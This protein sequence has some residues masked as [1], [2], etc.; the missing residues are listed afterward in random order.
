MKTN[1]YK[2]KRVFLLDGYGRQIPS[3]LH[4]LH[5]LGCITTV[6]CTSRLNAG[7]TSRYPKKK[8]LVP[9]LRDDMVAYRAAIMKELDSFPYDVIFP[10]LERTT[11]FCTSSEFHS[12]Y[13]DLKVISANR[14]AF[15]KAYDKQETLRTCQENGVPCPI[16]K[17]D[18]ETLDE[19]LAKVQFPLAAKPRKGSGGVGF[20]RIADRAMLDAYLADGTIKLEEYVLQEL[21]PKGGFQYAAFSMFG[22][23][24][25]PIFTLIAEVPRWFPIDGGPSCYIRTVDR[26]DIAQYATTLLEKLNW[27]GFSHIDFI[28]D[29]RDGV[30]KVMEINGR[31]PANVKICEWMGL[32][33]VKTMLDLVYGKNIAPNTKPIPA[34]RAMRYFHTDLLWFLKNPERFRAKPSWFYCLHQKDYIFSWKDPIPFFSYAIEHA[35]NYKKDMKKRQH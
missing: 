5:T 1:E 14:E 27:I 10:V 8:L 9:N 7:Y 19:Y 34:G 15:L 29:V 11:D 25:K 35:L 26:P 21:I 20:K 30:P 22:S 6:M 4:Q 23:D 2:G 32:Q 12:K 3:L 33:P 18:T 31:I 17:L 24:H 16:T 28:S 13:P